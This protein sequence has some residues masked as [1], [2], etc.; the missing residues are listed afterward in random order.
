MDS[1][2]E[3][4]WEGLSPRERLLYDLL[5]TGIAAVLGG[6]EESATRIVETAWKSADRLQ[7]ATDHGH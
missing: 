2:A 6:D 1:D 3:S 7:L 5:H 4:Y